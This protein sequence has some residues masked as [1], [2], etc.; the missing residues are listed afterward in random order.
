MKDEKKEYD[1]G[2]QSVGESEKTEKVAEVF[3]SVAG[4]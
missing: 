1:F 2:F 3:E 4:K